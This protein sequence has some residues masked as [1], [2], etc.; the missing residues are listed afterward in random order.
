MKRK[1][2]YLMLILLCLLAFVIFFHQENIKEQDVYE[3]CDEYVQMKEIPTLLDGIYFSANE[4]KEKIDVENFDGVLT[5]EAVQWIIQQ[6]GVSGHITYE[7]ENTSLTREEWAHVFEQIIDL[8][9]LSAKIEIMDEVVLENNDNT[10]KTGSG[11]YESLISGDVLKEMSAVSLYIK[12]KQIIGIRSIKAREGMLSNVYIKRADENSLDFLLDK[13]SYSIKLE[14]NTPKELECRVCDLVWENGVIT[15]VQLK[16]DTIQG[17]LLAVDD[18]MIE[19]EGYGQIKRSENLPIYKTYGTV[20]EKELEDIV[21][22]NMKVEYVV[23]KDR[24]EAILLVEPAKIGRIRVLLLSDTGEP[25]REKIYICASS[26]MKIV[27]EGEKALSCEENVLSVEELFSKTEKNHIKIKTKGEGELFFCDESGKVNSLGYQGTF[28]V[29]R[30]P[31]GYVVVNQ[32][33]LENYLCAVVPSEMPATYE[34]EALKAQ[35]ICARSYA[36]IQLN[37][38]DYAALGAHV[39]DSTNYQVYNKQQR[40]EK[41]TAAVWDTAGKIVSFMDEPAETYYYSTSS[42]V[43]SNGDCWNLTEDL[44]YAYLHSVYVADN[45]T[46]KDLSKESVFEEFLKEDSVMYYESDLPYFRWQAELDFNQEEIQNNL[47]TIIKDRKEKK[48]E[49]IQIITSKGENIENVDILG[50]MK[51]IAVTKRSTSG[52]ILQLTIQYKKGKI[53]IGNEYTIRMI[54][55]AGLEKLILADDS[56]KSEANLLPSAFCVLKKSG[57]NTYSVLGGGYG[58][59]I[60]MSQNGASEMAKEGRTC[61][62]ILNFF[63]KDIKIME[64]Q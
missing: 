58:H 4:W 55:G 30:Y 23:A 2:K 22:A 61:D 28:E 19:I 41:T 45:I 25:Y 57:K 60:G 64:I 21:I 62:E 53:L 29:Y 51:K 44:S 16:E 47:L 46:E 34:M 26:K 52:E 31:N 32:L 39:D 5:R 49:D 10:I 40:H 7:V 54:L 33:P 48:P 18:T 9:D 27:Y 15:K 17:D 38:G 8:V 14:L 6:V 12:E 35:A 50:K 42:G 24:V 63:F 13:T 1:R 20:E 56:D 37:R 11:L 59:G 36:Y 43:T 3:Y